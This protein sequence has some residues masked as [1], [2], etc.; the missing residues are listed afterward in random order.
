MKELFHQIASKVSAA[1]GSPATFLTAMLI[2][3]VWALTGPMFEYSNTWQLIINT[4]TTIVTFLMVFLIQNTQNRDAKAMH[5]KLDE[6]IRTSK[7]ARDSFVSLENISDGE[8]EE[9]DMYFRDLHS[10]QAVS[11]GT[12]KKLHQTIEA[13]HRRRLSLSGATQAI[14]Q[15]LK[16]P[17]NLTP[18]QH[19]SH[20][21]HT[22]E[23]A[24]QQQ[25]DSAKRW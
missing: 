15:M 23:H 18:Q 11:S 1:A 9:L 13:E 14:T 24:E 2:I 3:A 6:L 10:K 25:H 17:L 12:V 20:A 22:P 4:G 8:L 7:N 16:T 21:G 19:H 5:L